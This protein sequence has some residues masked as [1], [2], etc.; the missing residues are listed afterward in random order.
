[1]STPARPVVAVVTAHHQLEGAGF[2]VF[3]PFPTA[4]FELLDP[5]LLLDEMEPVDHEPGQAQGAPDHPHRG[6]ETVTYLLEGEFEHR[7]SMGNHGVIGPGGIQWMTAGDGV[8][9]SE[10]PS[11][12]IQ[13]DGGRVHG[14]QLWVNLPASAKRITPKYQGLDAD[15]LAIVEG[16]GWTVRVVAGSMLGAEGPAVTHT[17]IAY[18]H[19]TVQPGAE[20][21]IEAADD[22][23]AGIYGFKG[24][25]T[26][27]PDATDLPRRTLAVFERVAGD[28]VV[29]VPADAEEALDALV[30]TGRPLDE[31]VAR[32]GPFVMNTRDELVEAVEDFQ[33]GRMGRIAAT[34][35]V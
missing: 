17:P 1:M 22:H 35:T 12:R 30:L 18:A 3:R 14:F 15:D 8:V 10:M 2:G 23:S 20:L 25:G 6:F 24:S 27:G 16:D 28:L 19:L 26:V 9:H 29:A 33:A 5:F 13:T 34:G 11:R 7:D 21:R 4:A 32:Y 31:P